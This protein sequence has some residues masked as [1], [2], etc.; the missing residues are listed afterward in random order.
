MS[1]PFIFTVP[2]KIVIV[3]DINLKKIVFSGSL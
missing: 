1:V 3:I 2:T